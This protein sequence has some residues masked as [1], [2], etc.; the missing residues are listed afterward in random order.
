M[1]DNIICAAES[2]PPGYRAGFVQVSK[3]FVIF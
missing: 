2:S 1:N 3:L